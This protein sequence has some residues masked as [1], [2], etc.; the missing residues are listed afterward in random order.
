MKL[1]PGKHAAFTLLVV[2]SLFHNSE[3]A[4]TICR[5]MVTSP[6]EFF[7]P[8]SCLQF[9]WAVSTLSIAVLLFWI[10]AL[11]TEKPAVNHFISTAIAASILFNVFIPH[12]VAA[13]YTFSYTPGLI[14]ALMLNLPL[15]LIVL[16]RNQNEIGI[17][18]KF[19]KY[20]I[21]GLILGYLFFASIMFL[22]R[23]LV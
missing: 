13:L 17:K 3:E 22:V 11:R 14:T 23:Y 16:K 4:L 18:A 1:K 7:Q 6:V 2:A 20:I 10:V 15:S 5:S 21:V 8:L 9:L 19:I 12:V